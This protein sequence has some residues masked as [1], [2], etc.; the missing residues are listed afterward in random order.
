MSGLL[1][2]AEL[3]LENIA[4][5]ATYNSAFENDRHSES[6]LDEDV[7]D[8]AAQLLSKSQSLDLPPEYRVST[9][10]KLLYLGAYFIL[11]LSLTI[12][13]K[14]ILG[15]FH[16]PWLLTAVHATCLT[17]GCSLLR[18][19]GVFGVSHLEWRANLILVA[20]SFL[21]TANIAI[22]NVSL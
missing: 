21:F 6:S 2:N 4:T 3:E 9:K 20:Y 11:N 18:I 17:T 5:Y 22:S 19:F 12:Y 8:V 16:F 15:A 1:V 10:T 7:E 14:A 13:N